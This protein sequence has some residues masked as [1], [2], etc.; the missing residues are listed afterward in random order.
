MQEA[1]GTIDVGKNSNKGNDGV[2]ASQRTVIFEMSAEMAMVMMAL[3]PVEGGLFSRVFAEMTV[4][5][6]VLP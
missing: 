5:M 6:M 4:V 3:P 2:A 1:V